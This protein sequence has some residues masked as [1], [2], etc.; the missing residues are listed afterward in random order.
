MDDIRK[1]MAAEKIKMRSSSVNPEKPTI[2]EIDVLAWMENKANPGS[3]QQKTD[4]DK[5]IGGHKGGVTE[6]ELAA[7]LAT[8]F[9]IPGLKEAMNRE[10]NKIK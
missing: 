1:A 6:E 4:T 5:G 2:D 8:A 7:Q 10:K 9:D 3:G